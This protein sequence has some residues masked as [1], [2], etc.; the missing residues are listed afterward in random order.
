MSKTVDHWS[1]L[2]SKIKTKKSS[3]LKQPDPSDSESFELPKIIE[4][5]NNDSLIL[6]YGTFRKLKIFGNEYKNAIN[7][8]W[9]VASDLMKMK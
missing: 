6:S 3:F 5:K 8:E 7:F 2:A 9:P 1:D 4:S